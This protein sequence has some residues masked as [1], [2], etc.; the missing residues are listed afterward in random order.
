MDTAALPAHVHPSD[1]PWVE[2]WLRA[3]PFAERASACTEYDRIL[4]AAGF[5]FARYEANT[6]LRQAADLQS[7][8]VPAPPAP[9]RAHRDD[10]EQ[11]VRLI[12]QLPS[13]LQSPAAR[14]Y[15]AI[16][17]EAGGNPRKLR[18]QRQRAM[19]WLQRIGPVVG[20]V[21]R[22]RQPI[23]NAPMVAWL[24]YDDFGAKKWS[25]VLLHVLGALTGEDRLRLAE[26]WLGCVIPGRRLMRNGTGE[27]IRDEE[28]GAP[29]IDLGPAICRTHDH[30]YMRRAGRRQWRRWHSFSRMREK[31]V[32]TKYCT[33]VD[34][35]CAADAIRRAQNYLDGSE[36][37]SDDGAV[38]SLPTPTQ[39]ARARYAQLLAIS[40]GL[41]EA[42]GAAGMEARLITVTLPSIY[43]RASGT[44]KNRYPNPH[45]KGNTTPK[46]E[47]Q[48]LQDA[49][50]RCRR[51]LC[52]DRLN[53]ETAWV[54]ATQPHV[55]GTPHWHIVL[56]APSSRWDEL[57]AE[58][59][60]HMVEGIADREDA[61]TDHRLRIDMLQGGTDGA[62]AYVS[63]CI[64]YIARCVAE[65][66][67]GGDEADA[68]SAWASTW[69][70]RRY[71]CSQDSHATAWRFLARR[72]MPTPTPEL[73]GARDARMAGNHAEFV[74][75]VRA[76]GIK[77]AYRTVTN[78]YG[79]LVNRVI[80]LR[81]PGGDGTELVI[82]PT[83]RWQIRP[84][85]APTAADTCAQSASRFARAAK[86]EECSA[87]IDSVISKNQEAQQQSL[88]AKAEGRDVSYIPPPAGERGARAGP[89]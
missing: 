29:V 85:Q 7:Q 27:P 76:A 66:H 78:D 72:D 25:Q 71:Q 41:G 46:E 19:C 65:R 60:R 52:K 43:H 47:H 87:P 63:R 18:Q 54:R 30:N 35:E 37:V 59:Y 88:A 55:N 3:L 1:L 16:I 83:R 74:R 84:R 64:A 70:I 11:V 12:G 57:E 9:T 45:R 8:L 48:M 40:K 68:A 23:G 81:Q 15:D 39:I 21:W 13:E 51:Q 44:G 24:A 69:G 50:A 62:I 33:E 31:P 73:R 6:W 5:G 38:A 28:L 53:I 34:A 17:E 86:F 75:I 67:G 36:I 61:P 80:G 2:I 49:W 79:E 22:Q 77:P 10:V 82:V 56:W 58:L 20:G 32:A 14:R 89:G 42:A 4:S 26:Q